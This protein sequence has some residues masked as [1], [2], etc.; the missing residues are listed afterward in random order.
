MAESIMPELALLIQSIDQLLEQGR[1]FE[2]H[3]QATTVYRNNPHPQLLAQLGLALSK[4]GAPEQALETVG[5]AYQ[6]EPNNPEVA[7]ILGSIYKELFKK[8]QQTSFALQSRDTYLKNF[9]VTGNYYTGINAATMS[10]M[11]GSTSKGRE[12]ATRVIEQVEKLEAGYWELATLG[13]ANLLLKNKPKALE[14]YLEARKKAGNDWGKIT[15]VHNQLWLL[16]HYFPVSS[17]ILKLFAPSNVIAFAGHMIDAPTRSTPRFP[18]SIEPQIKESIRNSIRTLNARIGYS[19]LACGSD[20]IFAET[21]LEEGGEINLILPFQ[22]NDFTQTSVAFAGQE[23]IDRFLTIMNHNSVRFITN[24]EYQ[25]NDFLFALLG[26]VVLGAAIQRS[27]VSHVSAHLLTVQSEIDLKRKKGGTRDVADYWPAGLN[28]VNINP[29][30][31]LRHSA[32]SNLT[33]QTPSVASIA[34]TQAI[35]YLA[36]IGGDETVLS[37]AVKIL[38]SIIQSDPKFKNGL[39]SLKKVDAL[40]VAFPNEQ[41]SLELIANTT[42]RLRLVNRTKELRAALHLGVVPTDPAG[43]ENSL[44]LHEIES[45]GSKAPIN[46][47][48][49]THGFAALL[50]LSPRLYKIEQAGYIQAGDQTLGIY[51]VQLPT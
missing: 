43:F 14:F 2:A 51:T 46:T 8:N 16:N 20:I 11:A 26:R 31:F 4:M 25:G 18:S 15:S 7:G 9:E 13:E 3:L 21:I 37:E 24:A 36:Y 35:A 41:G 6:N 34:S 19:S 38:D 47:I 5:P 32:A 40:I 30:I 50:S 44:A 1:Y 29:D 45:L 17:E 39:S 12:I 23:W 28:H 33:E 10:A 22:I 49:A 48:L 42:K 27:R